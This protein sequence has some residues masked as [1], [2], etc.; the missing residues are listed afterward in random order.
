[1]L[2]HPS[3]GCFVYSTAIT[4]GPVTVAVTVQASDVTLDGLRDHCKG[5]GLDKAKWPEFMTRIDKIPLS[6]I[7]KV[8]RGVLEDF[9]WDEYKKTSQEGV[10]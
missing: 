10:S 3:V 7:G 9:V 1:M 5:V 4:S 2:S 8:Q 6:A